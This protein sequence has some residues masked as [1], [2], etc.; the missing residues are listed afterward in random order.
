MLYS[1]DLPDRFVLGT[2]GEPGQRT[3]VMQ[4]RAG[5][6][7]VSVV[8]EK[9]Q[10]RLL[11]ERLFALL[12]GIAILGE[13]DVP[14]PPEKATDNDPLDVPIDS[15]FRVGEIRIG[16]DRSAERVAVEVVDVDS[17]VTLVVRLTLRQT[18]EFIVRSQE[19]LAAGRP[20]CPFCGQP[21]DPKG[22][23]CPRVNGYRKTLLA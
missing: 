19:L 8:A 14:E 9:L 16:W 7:L 5:L 10:I 11:T 3:F 2:I 12:D 21:L 6:E 13:V 22:H 1:F 17:K 23:I 15:Q 20:A 4:A 18:Q